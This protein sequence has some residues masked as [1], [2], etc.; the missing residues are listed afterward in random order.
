[1]STSS[2]EEKLW[3]I[4]LFSF[5][6]T[7]VFHFQ[8]MQFDLLNILV[9]ENSGKVVTNLWKFCQSDKHFPLL[10]K[11]NFLHSFFFFFFFFFKKIKLLYLNIKH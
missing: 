8:K 11:Q 1:M 5:Y 4:T 9:F 10:L 7:L 3:I 2:Q 6:S